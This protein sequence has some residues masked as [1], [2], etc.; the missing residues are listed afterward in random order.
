MQRLFSVGR[1]PVF[2]DGYAPGIEKRKGDET[3]ILTLTCRVQPF[4]ARLATAIDD[5][6]GD[7]SGVK[8]ALFKLSSAEPKPHVK[9]VDFRLDCPRQ[10]L[11]VF[12][13]TDTEMSRIAFDHAKIA[14]TYARI[15]KDVNG[16]AFV[17]KASLGPVSRDEQQYI[18]EWLLGQRAVT[19]EEAEPSLEFDEADEGDEPDGGPR[20]ARPEPMWDESDEFNQA[21]DAA[22]HAPADTRTSDDRSVY[23]TPKRGSKKG[24]RKTDHDAER[25][26]QRAEGT[27]RAKAKK[28]R[29]AK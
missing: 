5:G 10:R 26:A 21:A 17:F 29:R 23:H 15:Q 7:D 22:E 18:H 2:L 27:K 28:A 1:V 11:I 6:L 24:P 25:Q 13:S 9:R 14:G 16:Y 19:F 8:V 20:A 4:D 12:A 3:K